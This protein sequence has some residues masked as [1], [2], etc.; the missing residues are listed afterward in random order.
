MNRKVSREQWIEAALAALGEAGLAALAI[1]PLARR[2]GVTKGSFYSHFASLDAFAGAVLG[3]WERVAT[4]QVIER[5]EGVALP[6]HRLK[7]LFETVWDR[8]E[9]LKIEAALLAGA[10]AGD[11]RVRPVYLRVNRRRLAYTTELYRG[12]GLADEE[13]RR[14]ATTAYGTYLG[15]L[16]LVALEGSTF[17]SQAELR[18]HAQHMG[19][20]LV[21]SLAGSAAQG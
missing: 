14:H 4:E 5:L 1:E 12:L 10:V 3:F 2:L 19:A 21:P 17:R 11:T 13:A 20:L 8:S 9:H 7:L 15:T 6:A 16:L 18:A